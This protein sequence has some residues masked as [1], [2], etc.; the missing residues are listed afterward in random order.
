MT[1]KI[2]FT[3]DGKAVV[4]DKGETIWDVAKREG[5]RI[6]HLCHVDL[7]GYRPDGN[8]R[9]CMVEIGGERVLAASCI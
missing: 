1:D 2:E 6:P 5:T 9:A 8:C 3:L 7:P 4:A